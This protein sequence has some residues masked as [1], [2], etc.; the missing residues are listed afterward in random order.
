MQ[1]H[2]ALSSA[3]VGNEK[4]SLFSKMAG[5][6]P[7]MVWLSDSK[8][9]RFFFS[10]KWLGFTGVQHSF[11]EGG[12]WLNLVH[13]HD[14]HRV[15]VLLQSAVASKQSFHIE[16]RLRRRDGAY[17]QILDSGTPEFADDGSLCGFLGGC[18]DLNETVH[19]AFRATAKESLTPQP[20]MDTNFNSPIAIW[21]LDCDFR[22]RKTNPAVHQQ[23][24]SDEDITGRKIWQVVPSI[25]E[26]MLE[27]V[28][29]EKSRIQVNCSNVLLAQRRP[30]G[31]P[32]WTIAAWPV[33]DSFG[34][35]I[36]VC[37]STA[38]DNTAVRSQTIS[39][40]VAALVHDLKS[41]LIGAERTFEAL[42]KGA[43]GALDQDLEKILQILNRGNHSMLE[44]IQNLIEMQR[45]DN[46]DVSLNLE[47]EDI[48]DLA[49]STLS[50]L[51]ALASDRA[52]VLQDNLPAE[53]EMMYVEGTSLK[54]V[55][56][57]LVSNALK[58]TNRGGAITLTGRKAGGKLLVSVADTG[59][60]IPAEDQP[61]LFERYFQ[62]CRRRRGTDGTGLGLYLCKNIIERH[63]GSISVAS[64]EGEGSTFT[65]ELPTA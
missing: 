45:S 4:L 44:M 35:T 46:G 57:N 49:R 48:Y 33:T 11:A 28:V 64:I 50:E 5:L 40:V 21:K 22:I 15:S 3:S 17:R 23:L 58:F 26:K 43:A 47:P 37:V 63:G 20:N 31:A 59:I 30:G 39:D 16:Y 32:S 56:H 27:R 14:R 19:S 41:P 24:E 51:S 60:G 9:S 8:G 18:T 52:I 36:A 54:R 25:S 65:L 55:F 13:A 1:T 7:R 6:I 34:N 10:P 38:E 42:F 12:G 29:T 53:P 2:K 61:H 62:G